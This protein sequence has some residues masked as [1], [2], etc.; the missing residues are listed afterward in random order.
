MMNGMPY[1]L[2]VILSSFTMA[3]VVE[4]GSFLTIKNLEK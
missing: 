4:L 2:K 3:P 1:S